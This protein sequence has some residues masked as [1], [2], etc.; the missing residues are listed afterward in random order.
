MI[1]LKSR[2]EIEVMAEGGKRLA[3]V[4]RRLEASVRAGMTTK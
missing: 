1:Y 2:E 4:L 3:A